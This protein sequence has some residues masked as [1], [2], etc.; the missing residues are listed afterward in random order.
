[1]GWSFANLRMIVPHVSYLSYRK[2]GP[3]A[4]WYKIIFGTI[5]AKFVKGM[6]RTAINTSMAYERKLKGL[7]YFF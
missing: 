6:M 3:M 5:N 1:M 4:T 7:P 2:F